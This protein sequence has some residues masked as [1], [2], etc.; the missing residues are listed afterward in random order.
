MYRRIV[1]ILV[2]VIGVFFLLVGFY[3]SFP[4]GPWGKLPDLHNQIWVWVGKVMPPVSYPS[5]TT[6]WGDNCVYIILLIVVGYG[7]FLIIG[8]TAKATPRAWEK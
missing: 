7:G 8:G 5:D 6:N 1:G 3:K 2:V 4:A